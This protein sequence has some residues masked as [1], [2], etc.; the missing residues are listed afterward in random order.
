MNS[1]CPNLSGGQT[2]ALTELQELQKSR[3]LVIKRSDKA[4]GWVLTNFYV[5]K[6]EGDKKLKGTYVEH[7]E[8]K[9]KYKEVTSGTLKQHHKQFKNMALEGEDKGYI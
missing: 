1:H 3:K 4:G 8:V 5:Y 2:K 7:N 9:S 6:S